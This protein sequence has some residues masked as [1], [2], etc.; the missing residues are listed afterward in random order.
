MLADLKIIG[1]EWASQKP[2]LM[3]LREQVFI[4]EQH[5]PPALEWD[6]QDATA[7]HL[8]AIHQGHEI[9][10]AR[11]V[12]N[13]IGRMAVLN[14]WRHHGVGK[15]LLDAAIQVIRQ[16]GFTYAKLSAQVHAIGFYQRAGFVF[17]SGEYQDAGIAHVDMQLSL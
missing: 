2:A 11:V 12:D 1:V 14:P 4:N 17:T 6:E 8:L 7:Q 5:V 13:Q 3:R 10:C 16:Q 15:A 9:G